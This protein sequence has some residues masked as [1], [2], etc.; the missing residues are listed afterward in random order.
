MGSLCAFCTAKGRADVQEQVRFAL[1]RGVLLATT[2]PTDRVHWPEIEGIAQAV[3]ER[4][5][6]TR[7]DVGEVILSIPV[8][9]IEKPRF[10]EDPRS[11]GAQSELMFV[12]VPRLAGARLAM[13]QTLAREPDGSESET[14]PALSSRNTGESRMRSGR[15]GC[16]IFR[17]QRGEGILW[18]GAAPAKPVVVGEPCD[19]RKRGKRASRSRYSTGPGEHSARKMI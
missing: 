15:G 16:I 7:D 4:T 3:L 5:T 1:Q 17:G 2:Q 8:E 6:P 19:P 14:R 11:R 12:T 13:P 10:R 9:V 18:P